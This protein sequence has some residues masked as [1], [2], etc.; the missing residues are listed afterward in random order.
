MTHTEAC[1]AINMIPKVGPVR[2]RNLLKIF[3]EPQDIL[4]APA[5][6][7]AAAE[8]ISQE[9]ARRIRSWEDEID[10]T[11]ELGRVQEAGVKVLTTRSENYPGSV[12]HHPR[13]PVVLVR[14][15]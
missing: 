12:A 2:L 7:L 4:S 9:I 15:G 8:G 3:A 14:L 5:D 11:A 1:L 6:R 13:S 10:L